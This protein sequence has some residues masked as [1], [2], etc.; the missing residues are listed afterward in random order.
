M[1]DNIK[2]DKVLGPM[3]KCTVFKAA[4]YLAEHDRKKI[5]TYPHH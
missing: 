2:L 1:I 4:E 5:K 3:L